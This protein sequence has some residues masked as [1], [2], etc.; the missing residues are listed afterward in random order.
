MS[1]RRQIGDV[2]QIADDDDS[3]YLGRIVAHANIR[4]NC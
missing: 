1:I 2:V 4:T 3:P